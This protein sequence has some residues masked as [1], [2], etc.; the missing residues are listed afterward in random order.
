MKRTLFSMLCCCSL[1]VNKEGN[2]G[3]L[4]NIFCSSFEIIMPDQPISIICILGQR[5]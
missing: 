2:S 5:L 1:N 3:K 4:K